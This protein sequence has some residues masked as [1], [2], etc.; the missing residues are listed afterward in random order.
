MSVKI[1]EKYTKTNTN[2]TNQN[3][4]KR[5]KYSKTKS[6]IE[7]RRINYSLTKINKIIKK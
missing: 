2:K 7:I 1:N 6:L 5:K 4:Q 3:R